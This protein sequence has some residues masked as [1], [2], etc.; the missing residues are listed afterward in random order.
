MESLCAQM[1]EDAHMVAVGCRDGRVRIVSTRPGTGLMHTLGDDFPGVKLPC[2]TALR[3]RPSSW[4]SSE[5]KNVL[6]VARDDEILHYHA[7]SGR[8]MSV[9]K[10]A[11]NQ[12]YALATCPTQPMFAS[13]G[14]DRNLRLYDEGKQAVAATMASGGGGAVTTESH[15]GHS[16]SVYALRWAPEDPNVLLSGGWDNTVQIWDRRT[17]TPERSIFGP[18]ICGDALD[19][20]GGTILTGSW[21]NQTPLQLWD[22]GTGKLMTNL[23]LHQPEPDS[24][25]LYSAQFG[26]DTHSSVVLAGGS[27]LH[28]GVHVMKKSGQV[29]GFSATP[30]S[31][32]AIH[33]VGSI[34]GLSVAACCAE[35]LV[36]MSVV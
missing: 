20:S 15:T 13:A 11:D 33:A 34:G 27:G 31:V 24:C 17:G 22:F 12:V 3:W 35:E 23:P 14:V 32:H 18:Y 10:E 5:T 7:T 2:C 8:V 21:R 4:H 28:P 9:L 25:F 36:L 1:T 19:M 26:V 6:I 30:S 29:V 16:N